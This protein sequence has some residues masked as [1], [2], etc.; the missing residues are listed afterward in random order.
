M[1]TYPYE[2]V[3]GHIVLDV[4]QRKMLVDTGDP[5]SV[6]DEPA[7]RIAGREYNVQQDYMGVSPQ[8]LSENVGASLNA[9]LVADILNR[10]DVLIEPET[11][12]VHLA[13]EQ[14][15]LPAQSLPLDFFMGVLIVTA[16]V[17]GRTLRL[18][19]DTSAQQ[20]YL[21]ADVT[22]GLPDAGEAEDFYPL[23]GEFT[24]P[25]FHVPVIIGGEQITLRVG[26]LP[27]LL[28]MMLMMA[29]T[30]NTGDSRT[31]AI[32]GVLRAEKAAHGPAREDSN[33]PVTKSVPWHRNGVARAL[34]RP[35]CTLSLERPRIIVT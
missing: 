30:R 24:T 22:S 34:I 17:N 25:T 16:S 6:G 10:Y 33:P 21:D 7:L 14:L 13:E 8:S 3:N 32:R 5:S 12:E 2:L 20:S 18:F 19:F 27:P 11:S 28:Q 29:D 23:F 1:Y 9:L 4:E 15:D 31:Q 26:N 35:A